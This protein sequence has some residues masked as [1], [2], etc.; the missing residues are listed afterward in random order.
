MGR[1]IPGAAMTISLWEGKQK[2]K[3]NLAW[4]NWTSQLILF[5]QEIRIPSPAIV[6]SALFI[7]GAVTGQKSKV[8]LLNIKGR[9]YGPI[10]N[11]I[12]VGE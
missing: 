5:Q 9:F 10:E 2:T 6:D 4:F 8:K 7:S 12:R 11:P 3:K 1:C